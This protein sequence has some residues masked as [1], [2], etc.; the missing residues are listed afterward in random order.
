MIVKN[1]SD[2]ELGYTQSFRYTPLTFGS[3]SSNKI[4]S[5]CESG[6]IDKEVVSIARYLYKFVCAPLDYILRDIP[7]LD[8]RKITRKMPELV[9]NRIFNMFILVSN[10]EEF[11]N[12]GL[13]FYTLDYGAILLLRSLIED[14]NLENWKATDLFMTGVKVK[15]A[16]MVIDFYNSLE[17][18]EFYNPYV[19]YASFGAKIKTKAVFKQNG[20]VYLVECVSKD[21]LADSSDSAITEKLLHYSQ[22]LGTEG[23]SYYF[24]ELPTLLVVVDSE[25]AKKIVK[26]R[27][28]GCNIPKLQFATLEVKDL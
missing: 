13:V 16:L 17:K 9:R 11:T 24:S 14:E 20:Q 7:G 10:N 2:I 18:P 19:I 26:A 4:L 1:L 25:N 28:E 15:K 3:Y 23:W 6:V 22:L 12:E 27:L 8:A 21:D 5:L